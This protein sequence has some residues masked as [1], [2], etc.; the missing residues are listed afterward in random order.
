M[1]DMAYEKYQHARKMAKLT[2]NDPVTYATLQYALTIHS[3]GWCEGAGERGYG[4]CGA[5]VGTG[6][7]SPDE[8]ILENKIMRHADAITIQIQSL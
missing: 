2:K 6:L 5:C 8:G 7:W 3:C 1:D 4:V